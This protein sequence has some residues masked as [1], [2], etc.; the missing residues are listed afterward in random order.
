MQDFVNSK[1]SIAN[2]KKCELTILNEL[3]FTLKPMTAYDF[4]YA[5]LQYF[6]Q[7]EEGSYSDPVDFAKSVHSVAQILDA[8]YSGKA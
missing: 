1:W 6:N 8:A 3:Q 4:V 5:F 2:I 7:D